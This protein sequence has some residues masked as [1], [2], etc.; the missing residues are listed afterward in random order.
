[1][2]KIRSHSGTKKRVRRTGSGKYAVKRH[3]RN[4]LL[5]QKNKR[6]KRLNRTLTLP[7]TEH[8]RLRGLVP[9]L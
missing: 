8:H 2:P 5:L 4:H 7:S 1:M 6:Q 3:S 9:Y